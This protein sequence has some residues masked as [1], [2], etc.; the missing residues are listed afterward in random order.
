VS[1]YVHVCVCVSACECVCAAVCTHVTVITQSPILRPHMSAC[2]YK[3]WVSTGSGLESGSLRTLG[4]YRMQA[5]SL[6]TSIFSPLAYHDTGLVTCYR[7][8]LLCPFTVSLYCV[9]LPR[10]PL[11]R[12]PLLCP[13]TT[14]Y[15][16]VSLYRVP[17]PRVP[18]P[19]YY[20]T[21]PC[22]FTV[23]LYRVHLLCLY[24]MC[25]FTTCP[26]TTSLYCVPSPRVPLPCSITTCSFTNV[27]IP[28]YRVPLQCAFTM[29]RG[30]VPCLKDK[31]ECKK[32]GVCNLRAAHFYNYGGCL[33]SSPT[34]CYAGLLKFTQHRDWHVAG[35]V[36]PLS[37]CTCSTAWFELH[38]TGSGVSQP[39]V[40][41]VSMRVKHCLVFI[42]KH[43]DWH[44]AATVFSI[45]LCTCS[46]AWFKLHSTG[47]GV[48]QPRVFLV[49]M[50]VKHCL[51][52]ITQH[53]DW[54]VAATVFS[55]SLC[56]CSTAW[57]D[58]T[59]HRDGKVGLLEFTQ[60]RVSHSQGD[61]QHRAWEQ[62]GLVRC[63]TRYRVQYQM[64]LH[65]TGPHT[66]AH[67]THTQH[68]FPAQL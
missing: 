59:Q 57:F 8:P 26:F 10:V 14:C 17:L 5:P 54:R 11:P 62:L 29:L 9:P 68:T 56:T 42:T 35:T 16:T 2:T 50:C 58:F 48:S 13:F 27:T 3:R 41:L 47:S 43:R 25:P 28:L 63:T 30:I 33:C 19:C 31:Q 15:F 6:L 67:H 64:V 18:L 60:N 7:V 49:S 23:C 66:S 55:I 34:Q 24:T 46:T 61:S 32:R 39:R 45:S 38:S 12:V 53:R 22:S 21:L 1:V 52:F 65:N 4:Q 20:T 44:V 37:L 40:F 36:F 51:V